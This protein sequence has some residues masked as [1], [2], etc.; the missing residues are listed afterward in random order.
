MSLSSPPN[1]EWATRA[2]IDT[3]SPLT[4]FDRGAADALGIR[5]G[6]TGAE[7][8]EIALLGKTRYVQFEIVDLCL[9]RD[10]SLAWTARVAFIK[11]PQFQMA[12]QGILGTEGFLDRFAVIFNKHYDWFE[13]CPADEQQ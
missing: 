7:T 6:N 4:V 11:D 1:G 9:L 5:I 10:P 2:L 8:G 3:G 13:V 12:F